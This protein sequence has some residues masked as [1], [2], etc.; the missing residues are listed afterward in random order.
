MSLDRRTFIVTSLAAM[1]GACQRR[2]QGD[3]VVDSATGRMYGMRSDGNPIFTDPTLF[4]NRRL[5]L[6]VRNMS[7]DSV[8]DLDSTRENLN[9]VFLDKGYEKSDGRDFGLKVDLNVLRSQQFDTSMLNEYAVLGA[10]GGLLAGGVAGSING[11]G[12]AKGAA[13]GLASGMT[14]GALAGY[15]NVDNIYVVLT[16]ATFG[17][18]RDSTKPR[19]VVT[20]EGSPRIEEWEERGYDAFRTTQRVLIANYGGGR[21][22][23][24]QEIAADIRER[25]IRSLASFL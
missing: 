2:N 18:R 15:F 7:G 3:M 25:Q 19:R 20:F 10:G 17:V 4:P 14:L 24:Q 8:W 16:E 5:K 12:I 22:V 21:G 23:T 9:K 13:I 11:D 1:V 6:S